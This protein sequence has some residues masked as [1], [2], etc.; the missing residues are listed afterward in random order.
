MY[1]QE[2]KGM[3][4]REWNRNQLEGTRLQDRTAAF[5]WRR[6]A[7]FILAAFCVLCPK[8]ARA[9]ARRI[10]LG[11]FGKAVSV[12]DPQI[13][14]DG[15]SIVYVVS[16]MNLEQ[17]RNDR[18]LVLQEIASGARRTLTH[19]RKDAG[20]PR[21]S[22]A[23]DRIAFLAAV[24]PAKEEKAQIFVLSMSGG[25]ALKI[26]DAPNGIEQFAWRPS[27]T[28]IAY[29]TADE[30]E[31][32]KD[33]EK[34]LD[35]FE[36]GDN[37]YLETKAPTPSHIWLI[38]VD[39]GKPRRLTSGS[40][41][42]PKVLPPSSPSSPI[43][44]SPDGKLLTFTKQEDPHSG[45]S[46][47]RT[48]QILNVDS[49]EI[50]KLTK[51]EKFE[52]F[53]LF[54]PDGSQL[55]YWYPRD[56]DRANQNEI[57]VT[58][59]AG[60]DGQDVTRA[61]DRNILRGIWM[62]DGKSLLVGGHDG[63]QVSLWLQPLG[64]AAKKLPL[65][66]VS[67]SWSFWVDA[68]VGRN[69]EIA[70][71]GSTPNQP[72]ELYY[73]ATPND[74]PKRLTNNNQEIAA[75]ALGRT[76]RFEWQGPDKFHEDGVIIY[77]PGFQKD[78]KYPLVLII[79]GG[80]R[81]TTTTQYSFLPQFVAAHDCVVFQPNYRGSENLGN[82]YTRAIWN[83]AGD[84]PGR[85]VMAGIEA[86]KKLGF[87]DESKIAVSGWSYG[88][89]MTTWLMG[90]YQI[91]KVAVAG[92]AVT[93]MYDQYNLADFNVTERYIFSGSPYVGDNIKGYREQSPITYASQMKTPTLILSDTGDFRVTIT[94]S[95]E[96]FHALKDNGV[97]VRFFAYPV[98]GHFPNDPV[99]QMD[100]Y[101]R[102]S[103]WL[104]EHLK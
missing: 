28:E 51:H 100:V 11:D 38:A 3:T 33:I 22:P 63:T 35:A 93:N 55:A 8:G 87:V 96:L 101:R 62:P 25:D 26:T 37:G 68:T 97:P 41:T 94:Q 56:G 99:R 49:G 24:G 77:P 74:P 31:N 85:D 36:V 39:G 12:S 13:S 84:G 9:Q 66:D 70:F 48:V 102:W 53:G 61:I 76:E 45:D 58:S 21:W 4:A 10:E 15:K 14:P 98:S 34:H 50:R 83:D 72:S 88:G 6:F 44:F 82:A 19:D 30:A 64:G 104:V 57:H 46:D 40:W 81:A 71:A 17:D 23:G 90:H 69:G 78:K 59:V 89:Y 54:S 103:E 79:H 65:G 67:P 7:A 47:G 80:P 2:E 95:Y 92:A 20:S 42:L 18:D 29:V 27:G 73:M 86:L 91:W 16:R 52:G 1:R 32:K 5:S 60:G 43:S 75:L